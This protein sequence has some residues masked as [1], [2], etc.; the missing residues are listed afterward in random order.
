MAGILIDDV[1]SFPFI[2]GKLSQFETFYFKAYELIL[3]GGVDE[4]LE[5]RGFKSLFYNPIVHSFKMKLKS[6]LDVVNYPQHYSM[7]EQ[8]MFP[9]KHNSHVDRPFLINPGRAMVPEV[10]VIEHYI[11]TFGLDSLEIPED[12]LSMHQIQLKVC[13]TGPIELYIKTDL[14]FTI[15]KDLLINL[16][17][18]INYFIKNSLILDKKQIKTRVVALDEPSL[19]FIDLYNVDEDDLVQC[20]DIAVDGIPK[21]VLIQIHLHSLR[22][23][24]IPLKTRNIDVLTCEFASDNSNVI[25]RSILESHG[26]KMRVGICRTNYNAILGQFLEKG[27]EIKNS[28]DDQLKLID[29]PSKIKTNF[30]RALEHYGPENILFI[31]PDCGLSSWAPPELAQILLQRVVKAAREV[32]KTLG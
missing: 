14:G 9:I 1:G 31:G 7:H 2:E 20:L 32:N 21:D 23:A 13:V 15:Y 16:C 29:S 10:K 24:I 8:F 28:W 27:I 30:K 4:A 3:K 12:S 26:K 25:D 17:K 6:G 5:N 18:S 19:G 22:D 11:D